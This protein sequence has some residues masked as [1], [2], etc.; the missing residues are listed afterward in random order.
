MVIIVLGSGPPFPPINQSRLP[1]PPYNQVGPTT[2]VEFI[3]VDFG[4]STSLEFKI[5]TE[6]VN[7]FL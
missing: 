6:Q 1:V 2:K 4:S 3:E 7:P 5:G